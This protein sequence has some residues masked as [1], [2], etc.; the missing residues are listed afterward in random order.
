MLLPPTSARQA[1]DLPDAHERA[2]IVAAARGLYLQQG[3]AEV[4]MGDIGR[5]LRMPEHAVHRWFASK[6]PLVEA[7]VDAHATFIQTELFRHKE[8]CSTAVEELL[9]LR[10]W[11]S[12]EMSVSLSPFFQQLAADYPDCRQRWQNHMDSFPVEHLRNNLRWGILQDLYHPA[13]DVEVHVARWFAQVRQ[14]STPEAAG[15]D[16]AEAHWAMLNVFMADITTPAG[17]LVARRL[18][19]AHPFY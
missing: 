1:A 13:L 6:V 7:V 17:A 8:H 19:E 14:L 10:N 15:I 11:V 16:G 18:Q 3:I 4:S 12:Q 5:H 2:R 9:I